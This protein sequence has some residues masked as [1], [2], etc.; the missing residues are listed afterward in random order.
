VSLMT[1]LFLSYRLKARTKIKK[2]SRVTKI[3]WTPKVLVIRL[4][5]VSSPK[6]RQALVLQP[7]V[8]RVPI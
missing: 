5:A 7:L 1:K 4:L 3:I 2:Q 8:H 6:Q